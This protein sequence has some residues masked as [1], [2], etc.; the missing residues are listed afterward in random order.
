MKWD[1]D[2]DNGAFGILYDRFGDWIPFPLR[3]DHYTGDVVRFEEETPEE[4]GC[5]PKI[6]HN[7]GEAVR[8]LVRYAA[9]LKFIPQEELPHPIKEMLLLANKAKP[10]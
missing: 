9:P 2:V 7:K 8:L 5:F 10:L 6:N 3:A 4:L 1:S